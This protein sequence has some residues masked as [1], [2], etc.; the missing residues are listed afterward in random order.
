MDLKFRSCILIKLNNLYNR[1][2]EYN[3]CLTLCINKSKYIIS[4]L[5]DKDK[6]LDDQNNET[7]CDSINT[8]FNDNSIKLLFYYTF[9]FF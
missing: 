1:V 6:L 3:L 4:L 8:L 9:H 7:I 5:E 2:I